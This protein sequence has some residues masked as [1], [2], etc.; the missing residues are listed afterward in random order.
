MDE[1]EEDEEDRAAVFHPEEMLPLL[2]DAVWNKYRGSTE[3]KT[4]IWARILVQLALI[5]RSSDLAWTA[6]GT[7]YCPDK[8]DV[9]F[10]VDVHHYYECGLPNHI[11]IKWRNWKGR[12]LRK[13]VPYAVRLCANP[14]NPKYCPVTWLLRHWAIDWKNGVSL[15]EGPILPPIHTRTHQEQ[16]K[17]LFRLVGKP[18]FSSHSFRRSGAQWA[19]R[20]GLDTLA[21]KDIGRWQSLANVE[22]YMAEGVAYTKRRLEELGTTTDPIVQFWVFDE[23]TRL[24]SMLTHSKQSGRKSNRRPR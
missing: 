6:K 15:T 10:P 21:I 12:K 24:D 13:G 4:G 9:E 5:A 23:R 17:G 11:I 1:Y 16:M 19:A 20:C 22:R 14:I 3:K 8:S 18:H 2:W 7:K